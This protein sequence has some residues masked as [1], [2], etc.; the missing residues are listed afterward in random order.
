MGF[1]RSL[2]GVRRS[3]SLL[4]GTWL[5]SWPAA[6]GITTITRTTAALGRGPGSG[7]AVQPHILL[8]DGR[9]MCVSGLETS[10]EDPEQGLH[11]G[12][13][14]PLPLPVPFSSL[15]GFCLFFWTL[16]S[17]PRRTKPRGSISTS[18]C[19]PNKRGSETAYGSI[20]IGRV[21]RNW[22]GLV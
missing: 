22:S 2:C 9:N 17:T 14:F 21:L 1:S 8:A 6:V 18:E 4:E 11:S 12:S 7:Q 20:W 16:T 10:S 3:E 5:F 19:L 15:L 13:V